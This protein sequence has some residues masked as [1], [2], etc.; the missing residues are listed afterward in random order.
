MKP[1][2]IHA[3]AEAEVGEAIAYYEAQRVGWHAHVFVAG[4]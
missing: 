4:L 3:E 1:L 2:A